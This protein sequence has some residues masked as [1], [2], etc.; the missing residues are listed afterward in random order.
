MAQDEWVGALR[1]PVPH[2]FRESTGPGM[3]DG[4]PILSGQ[5]AGMSPPF[6]F[7]EC[8]A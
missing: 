3:V 2:P 7:W 8:A 1:Y 5:A 6:D 4:I